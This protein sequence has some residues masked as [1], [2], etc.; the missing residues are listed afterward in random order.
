MNSED[1]GEAKEGIGA[2]EMGEIEELG[3]RDVLSGEDELMRTDDREA[4]K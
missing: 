4:L 1:V 3:D 2:Q